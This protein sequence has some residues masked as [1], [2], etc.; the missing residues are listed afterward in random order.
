MELQPQLA[1]AQRS[2]KNRLQIT[3]LHPGNKLSTRKKRTLYN[4]LLKAIWLHAAPVWGSATKPNIKILQRLQNTIF[5]GIF[6]TISSARKLTSNPFI[7]V[8]SK[9][10][11]KYE[12]RLHG[13]PN[14]EVIELLADPPMHRLKRKHFNEIFS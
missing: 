1:N 11:R 8:I 7:D 6:A 9:L 4:S 14:V 13:H 3:T 10:T 5:R 12:C 2:C